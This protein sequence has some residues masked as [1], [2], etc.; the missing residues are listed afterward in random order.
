MPVTSSAAAQANLIWRARS[1]MSL[2]ELGLEVV[3]SEVS[4][5]DGGALE[6]EIAA[7]WFVSV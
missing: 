7:A 6:E 1:I 2:Y 4:G 5:R 3:V